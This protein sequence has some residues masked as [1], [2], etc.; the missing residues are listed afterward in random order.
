MK[1]WTKDDFANLS[2]QQL[3]TLYQN[4][5][6]QNAHELVALIEET[7]LPFV[8]GPGLA[9]DSPMGRKM[10]RI[11]N[12]VEGVAAGIAATKRGVPALAGIEPL[13]IQALGKVYG[14]TYEATVQAGYL[15]ALMMRKNGYRNSGAK[16]PVNNGAAKTAE[17]FELD[18]E[19]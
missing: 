7:G 17:I 8:D 9:L 15:T 4:A 3:G 16:G 12:S 2:R 6:K 19:Q 11:I 1:R 5:R 14:N 13:I 18:R 10:R